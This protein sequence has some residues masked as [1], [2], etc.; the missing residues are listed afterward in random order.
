MLTIRVEYGKGSMH[1]EVHVNIATFNVALRAPETDI[2]FNSGKHADTSRM[3]S[4]S[5]RFQGV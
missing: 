2:F 3:I 5:A 4:L 1:Y